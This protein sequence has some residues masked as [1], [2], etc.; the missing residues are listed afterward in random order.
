MIIIQNEW[1]N[2]SQNTLLNLVKS[3]PRRI[4]AVIKSKGNPTK[5]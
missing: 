2:I 1:Y 5:Y 4:K 3:M